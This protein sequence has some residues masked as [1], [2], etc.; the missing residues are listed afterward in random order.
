MGEGYT[1]GSGWGDPRGIRWGSAGDPRL[2]WGIRACGGVFSL[3]FWGDPF[4]TTFPLY[5]IRRRECDFSGCTGQAMPASASKR[6]A[7]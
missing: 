3:R 4:E 2:V 7:F 6:T 5:N 1:W